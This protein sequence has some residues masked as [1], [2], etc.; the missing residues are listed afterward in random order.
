MGCR[1]SQVRILSPRIERAV[2]SVCRP[3]VTLDTRS[4]C[5]GPGN[6][7]VSIRRPRP[8]VH[9]TQQF[10]T[11]ARC[12]CNQTRPLIR[13]A[14]VRAG[15]TFAVGLSVSSQ[16]KRPQLCKRTAQDKQFR[17]RV[18]VIGQRSA[19]G[20]SHQHLPIAKRDVRR[21]QQRIERGPKG[22]NVE[23]PAAVVTLGDVTLSVPAFDACQ[24]G[25][26]HIPVENLY[27][28]PRH[29]EHRRIPGRQRR[30]SSVLSCSRDAAFRA[31]LWR[32]IRRY[33]PHVD[34]LAVERFA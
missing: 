25:R 22:V 29:V 31:V 6:R 20:V 10:P 18:H 3:L 14:I 27:E 30:R 26:H 19:R 33:R 21:R 1:R 11:I 7:S 23:G 5:N 24:P 12:R 15:H 2:D 9:V 4:T 16:G 17:I 28:P 34:N 32:G 8:L 13:R